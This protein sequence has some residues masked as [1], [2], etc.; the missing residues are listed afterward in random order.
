MHNDKLVLLANLYFTED[1]LLLL[2]YPLIL[3]LTVVTAATPGLDS[4]GINIMYLFM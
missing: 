1:S 4:Y 2:H 3:L